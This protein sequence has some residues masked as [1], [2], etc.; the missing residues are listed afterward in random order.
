MHINSQQKVSAKRSYII[1][2]FRL[3]VAT[4][5]NIEQ[6]SLMSLQSQSEELEKVLHTCERSIQKRATYF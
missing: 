2:I 5:R 4:L 3:H 6:F 1:I